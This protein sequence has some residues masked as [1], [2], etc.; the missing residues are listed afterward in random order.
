MTQRIDELNARIEENPHDAELHLELGVELAVDGENA[1]A[2]EAWTKALELDP[3][4]AEAHYNLGV[5][6]GRSFIEDIAVDELWE[7]LTDEEILF[8]NAVKHLRDALAIDSQLIPALNNLGHLY[9]I[10][11]RFE[12]AKTCYEDS[13][14][15]DADQPDVREDLSTLGP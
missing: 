2:V 15:I 1:A 14:R 12:E 7:D 9:A 13:L 8:E 5:L 6:Y 3:G 4:L 10:R 11:G